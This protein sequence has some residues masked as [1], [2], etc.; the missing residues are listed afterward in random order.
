MNS[1]AMHPEWRMGGITT[2]HV[3][4]Y[5]YAMLP[6]RDDVLNTFDKIIGCVRK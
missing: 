6:A 5:L 3:E 1:K 4:D 2:S